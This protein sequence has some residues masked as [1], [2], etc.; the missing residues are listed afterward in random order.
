MV[1]MGAEGVQSE[2]D[3][4]GQQR[5]LPGQY[6][7]VVKD[8]TEKSADERRNHDQVILDFEVLMGTTPGQEGRTI[9]EYFAV[10]EK[11]VC[12]LQKLALCLG[13]LKPG[14][15][16]RDVDFA[17]AA[18]R[19]LV[20]AIEENKYKTKDGQEKEGVRVGFL[21]FWSL[22]NKEVADVPKDAE[23]IKI[24]ASGGQMPAGDTGT[25]QAAGGDDWAGV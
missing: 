11:A 20:I 23:A 8:A 1:T 25:G 22:D 12:R 21:G 18:G 2:N 15:E 7:V 3:I 6:H 4:E 14:E 16:E 17:A 24:A 5:P 19:Q 10:T 9:T 13:L